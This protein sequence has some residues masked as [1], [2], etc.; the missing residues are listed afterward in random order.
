MTPLMKAVG[1]RRVEAVR[2]L[3]AAG[4]RPDEKSDAGLTALEIAERIGA[5]D[6]AEALSSSLEV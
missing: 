3:L 1:S 6:I 4:A 5:K 2:A